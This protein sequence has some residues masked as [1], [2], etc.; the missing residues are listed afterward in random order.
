MPTTRTLPLRG[1]KA[2]KQT[3]MKDKDSPKEK[4]KR[5]EIRLADVRN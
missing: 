4:V 2:Y 3:Q 1:V 5:I